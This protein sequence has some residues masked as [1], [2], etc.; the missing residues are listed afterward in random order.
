MNAKR[1][2][3][4]IRWTLPLCAVVPL[5]SGIFLTGWLA[6][7]SGQQAVEELA[8]EVSTEVAANIEKE[9]TSYLTRTSM[10]AAAFSAEVASGGIDIKDTADLRQT[11]W[12]LTRSDLV[13]QTLYY[14]N[15]SGEFVYSHYQDGQS[16]IDL[17]DK[18]TD[19]RRTPYYTDDAGKITQQ[20]PD[21]EYDNESYNTYDPRKRDWYK[22]AVATKEV[23]W[24]DVY[25][26]KGIERLTLTHSTPILNSAS[27]VQGVFG[28]DVYLF[29]LS[30][31]LKN[32]AISPNAHTFVIETSGTLIATS[33]EYG[34][35]HD[36][37]TLVAAVDSPDP[38]VRAT[39]NHLL[40]TFGNLNQADNQYAFTFE[41]EGEKQLAHVYRLRALGIDWLMGVTIPQSDYMG[42]I[43]ETTRRTVL[44][45]LAVTGI[46][47]LLSLAAALY[48]IHPINKLTQA[49]IDIKNNQ[50]SPD[51]LAD[52]IARPDEFSE[53]ANLFNDMAIVVVSREQS[54]AEQVKL[55]ETEI[56]QREGRGNNRQK[57]ETL[58]KRAEKARQAYIDR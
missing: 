43:K 32:L 38:L 42:N 47:S 18:T 44:I 52:I 29:E 40:K 9:V 12:Q 21:S 7:R 51:N 23:A 19:F 14:G 8:T 3:L 6:F 10:V 49:A 13:D 58:L 50:F 35:D 36:E 31:F 54:L 34:T 16:R 37:A 45:G 33:S 17:R 57:L 11:L 30:N 25:I 5:I 48:I 4:T 1:K 2:H 55:L 20:L 15:E 53:L 39:A 56:H 41:I 26:A 46:A 27:Q 28:V 22:D 24:S